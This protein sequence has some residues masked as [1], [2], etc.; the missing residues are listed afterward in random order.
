MNIV[1]W[2]VRNILAI[3]FVIV[4]IPMIPAYIATTSPVPA[5]ATVTVI[6]KTDAPKYVLTVEDEVGSISEV[7]TTLSKYNKTTVG[8]VTEVR[9]QVVGQTKYIFGLFYMLGW[10]MIVGGWVTGWVVINWTVIQHWA[11]TRSSY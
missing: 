6:S 1:K 5:K 7:T 4:T 2:F 11:D 3:T 8:D 9:R 10:F